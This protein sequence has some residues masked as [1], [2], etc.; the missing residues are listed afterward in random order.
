MPVDLLIRG[1]TIY[2]GEAAPFASDVAVSGDRIV[3]VG[4]ALSV[5]ARR[6]IA[7]SGM[8][9]APGFIDPHTHAGEMLA[10][11]DG[12]T[13][14]A[15]PFLLQGVT[16]VVIG[17]DGGGDPDVAGT[18]GRMR[19]IGVNI[20]THV[21]FGAVR[22]RVIG[23]ADRAPTAYELVAMRR[24]VARGMCEGAIGLS[25]G[26]FYAPQRFAKTAEVTALAAEAGARGAIYDSH[27]RDESSYSIGVE[28]A[29]GEALAIGR[30]ARV[31][32]NISH[33]KVLGR[34]V[35]GRAPVV[36][37]MI[38][39]ARAAGQRVTADQYPY[40]ASGTSLVAALVPGWAQD[41]GRPALLKRLD[42]VALAARLAAEMRAN[43]VRR[44]GAEKLLVTEGAAAGRTLAQVAAGGD[45]VAAAIA[46][47]R[48]A[49]PA[50]V[51]FNMDE[52]DI[53]AFMRQPWVITG[54][55]ASS[56][57][58]RFY[59]TFARKYAVY[60]KQR[61]IISLRAFVERST[62]LTA[63]T[64]G[65]ADRG[66]IAPGKIADIVVFD[67]QHYAARAFYASPT[68]LA[69]GVRSVV[70]N[71][72]VAVDDG[73]ATGIAAGRAIRHVPRAGRCP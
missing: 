69:T 45:P 8:I 43:L 73:R 13:R 23:A 59:G 25:T 20:A 38:E 63:D 10:A 42:D 15:L 11:K 4:P 26:L 68:L 29:I 46:V 72:Q 71:G 7:A 47:I 36:I 66:R 21:G 65:F 3:A 56:G 18:L 50:V 22:Q 5:R 67:P 14:L 30:A 39:A 17:N 53:A 57:H 58:P 35:W 32:V 16:S 1:G 40:D 6:T 44:G 54:S 61:R 62:A 2:T 31:P 70:V 33:I 64:L 60:V 55:D 9:V 41:G 34:D 28:A 27:V 24:L 52:R 48:T 19:G 12:R 51:S 37:A 49:D